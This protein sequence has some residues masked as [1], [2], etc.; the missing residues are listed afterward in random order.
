M[1]T[2]HVNNSDA[3]A[4]VKVLDFGWALVGSLCS[5]MLADFGAEVVKVESA[6][7]PCLSRIDKQVSVSERGNLNDK[8]WFSHFNSSK[9]SLQ[10]NIK[11]PRMR[12]VLDPLIDWADVIVEN[13]SPGT[14]ESLGLAYRQIQPKRPDIIMVSG[15]VFGQSGP[16]ANNWGVDGTGAALA[17]RMY[18]TG[19]A[20]KD[21]VTP[22]VPYGDVVLPHIMVATVCAALEY[23]RQ[24][25]E[26]Q[27]IDASMYEV[28]AQQMSESLFNA[29][30][31]NAAQQ[32][33]GNYRAPT[34]Y[35]GVYPCLDTES[36]SKWIAISFSA[37]DE[38]KTF[39]QLLSDQVLPT[40]EDLQQ[41]TPE[42]AADLDKTIATW[43]QSQERYA[44]MIK[45]QQQGIAAG[46]VQD[47]ADTFANDPQLQH[48][49]YLQPLVHP[50]LGEF[51]HQTPPVKLSRTPARLK[52]APAMGEHTL[53]ICKDII[54]LSDEQIQSLQ[55]DDV[56][57]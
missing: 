38:W 40:A 5:K 13:F 2:S 11:H 42:Q 37:K 12:E 41:L 27:H 34:L 31:T 54:G 15:S 17:G 29:Q 21:P 48:R 52:L 45:L 28:C 20:D 1:D 16:Y 50:I 49:Q 39:T 7:R 36:N 24:T 22:S 8:P 35:Q 51:G 18:M 53:K 3:L 46:V 14:M 55:D 32:R 57:Q 33:M 25:G 43:T 10:I 47:I 44:L 6:L 26:G 9:L 30:V 4:G 56:F 19:W 23:K